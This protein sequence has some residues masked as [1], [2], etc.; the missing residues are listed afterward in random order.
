MKKFNIINILLFLAGVA[1]GPA[2][3]FQASEATESPP[4]PALSLDDLRTFT[5]VFTQIRNN[6]VEPVDDKA[7]LNSAINGMLSDLD[8][9]SAYLLDDE[10]DDLDENSRGR[11]DGVGVNVQIV[12]RRI[13][14]QAV[15]SPSPADEA[16]I[17]PRD[18]I[19]SIDGRPVREA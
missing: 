1:T 6:Y 10:F 13:V 19:L 9:H 16:G 3:A 15:I 7:L 8:P 4:P 11:F 14:V 17:N 5:D 12:D 2:L 18:V